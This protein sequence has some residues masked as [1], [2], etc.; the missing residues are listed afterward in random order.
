MK[1]EVFKY[2]CYMSAL[3]NCTYGNINF[4]LGSFGGMGAASAKC[5][6]HERSDLFLIFLS[7]FDLG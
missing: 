4:Y 6:V 5:K 2:G 3:C 1:G 7:D